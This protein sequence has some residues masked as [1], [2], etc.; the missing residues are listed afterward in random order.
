MALSPQYADGSVLCWTAETLR[1]SAARGC[2]QG[3]V[4]S[5]LLWSLVVDD[6]LWGLNSNGYYTV[7]YAD[8][9]AILINGKF[10]H[11]VSEV[12]QTALN[13][14]QKWC[15]KTNLSINPNNTVIIPLTRKREIKGLK[16]PIL[17]NKM[18]QLSS[19]VKYLGITLDKGLTWKK[20]LDKA[21]NKAYKAFL[22]M[23]T[24]IWKNLGTVTKGGILDIYCGLRPI[25]MYAVTIW[26]PRVKLKTSQ[27]EL[28]KL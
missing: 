18:I 28:S 9:K 14:V 26:W 16:E 24:H 3:S 7:R 22:Y 11:T 2:P 13:T 4:L 25:I 20:Q 27:A 8:D 6:L 5:P 23:H 15:E 21:I 1:A 12:L 17:F 19:E 10:P